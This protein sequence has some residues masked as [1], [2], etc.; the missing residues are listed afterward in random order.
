MN[1]HF[2]N[3]VEMLVNKYFLDIRQVG[4]DLLRVEEEI[5]QHYFSP[6]HLFDRNYFLLATGKLS[7]EYKRM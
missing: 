1:K 7:E 6:N 2:I 5:Q 3:G 4:E